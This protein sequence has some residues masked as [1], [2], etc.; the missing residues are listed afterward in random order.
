M[1]TKVVDRTMIRNK[2]KEI[3]EDR[4]CD[5]PTLVLW[6]IK[7]R[8]DFPDNLRFAAVC[9]SWQR[10]SPSYS[11]IHIHN[12]PW[13]MITRGVYMSKREF[14]STS[15]GNKYSIPFVDFCSVFKARVVALR[16]FND[17]KELPWS[18][19]WSFHLFTLSFYEDEDRVA[20]KGCK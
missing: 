10:A 19:F 8:L 4:W 13:I 18:E 1:I 6:G 14:I 15:T 9:K 2:E 5:L 16:G 17:L 7:D 11:K 3:K 12:P 20:I